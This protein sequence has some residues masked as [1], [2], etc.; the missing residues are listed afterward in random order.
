VDKVVVHI[1]GRDRVLRF[2][3]DKVERAEELMGGVDL[4]DVLA[5]KRTVK[6]I[7]V[8]AAVGFSTEKERVSPAAV[9]EWIKADPHAY[10]QLES[11]VVLAIAAHM[12]DRGS[13]TD[14][15][16]RL[17]GEAH[18]KDFGGVAGTGS[19]RPLDDS[20]STPSSSED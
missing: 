16:L 5:G 10:R 3:F 18:A 2:D 14:E 19:S 1:A 12:N 8:I 7:R 17:L 9:A 13:V 6:N 15:E 11:A 20:G 4:R